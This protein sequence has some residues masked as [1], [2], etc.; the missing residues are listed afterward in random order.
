MYF[1][2]MAC[3]YTAMGLSLSGFCACLVLWQDMQRDGS[4]GSG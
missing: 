2:G 4:A 1:Q 3:G